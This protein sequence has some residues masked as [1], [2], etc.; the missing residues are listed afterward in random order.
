MHARAFT[1]TLR[2]CLFSSWRGHKRPIAL[3]PANKLPISRGSEPGSSGPQSQWNC[4]FPVSRDLAQR[5][6]G[7]EHRRAERD[8]RQGQT[9][10]QAWFT[11]KETP[12]DCEEGWGR[13]APTCIPHR[14]RRAGCHPWPLFGVEV[15]ERE[16][17][18]FCLHS[19]ELANCLS[20]RPTI[21]QGLF[22]VLSLK[23][24]LWATVKEPA[25]RGC[26]QGS[27]GN[28]FH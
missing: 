28:G 26:L 8:R 4:E 24:V 7:L 10:T 15:A 11:A 1:E 5:Q 6:V 20:R 25:G 9:G 23:S 21:R 12:D 3:A 18:L 14:G 22:Q 16:S 27:W 17:S 2:K 19:G 13:P